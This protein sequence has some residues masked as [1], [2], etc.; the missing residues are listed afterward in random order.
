MRQPFNNMT[1]I[2]DAHQDLA[3]N[4]INLGRD[5]TRSAYDIRE[6]EKHTPIPAYNGNTLLGWPQYQ[7]ANV[8]IVFGTLFCTPKRRH[9]AT[10]DIQVYETPEEA[11]TLYRQDLDAYLRLAD[12][13]PDKFRLIFTKTDLTSHIEQ[14]QSQAGETPPPVGIVILMEGADGILEPEQVEQWYQWGVRL[15]G[16][17]WAGNRF[18]GGTLEPGPLTKLGYRLLETM[19]DVGF[20]L[21]ISHMDHEAARQSLDFYAGQVVATHAN[22][23]AL[24]NGIPINRHLKDETIHQL[25][26][27]NGVIGMVP[28]NPFLDWHWKENGGRTSVSLEHFVA[29]LD[30]VCQIAGNTKHV[31]IGTDFDGGFGVELAPHD[32]DTIA[33][34]PKLKTQLANKGYNQEDVDRI[35]SRNWLRVLENNLPA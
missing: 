3:W 24:L 10:Y 19:A 35:L 29:Q 18:C 9:Q 30:H 32:I 2:I 4:M 25:I 5:Y 12:Q 20:I 22:A 26:E 16:P 6:S 33:D 13:H 34:L 23:E 21:D 8:A 31:G 1:L 28:M 15:I 7:Q 17:A 27:R 11:Y 14:W